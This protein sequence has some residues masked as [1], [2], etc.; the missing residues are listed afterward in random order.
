V[1]GAEALPLFLIDEAGRVTPFTADVA[2]ALK[3]GQALIS[4]VPARGPA[5]R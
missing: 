4:L 1:H 3:P 2:L 5:A